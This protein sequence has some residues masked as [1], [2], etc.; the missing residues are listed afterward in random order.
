MPLR[1]CALGAWNERA[2]QSRSA[3]AKMPYRRP[4]SANEYRLP[5][6]QVVQNAPVYAHLTSIRIQLLRK[7]QPQL[8]TR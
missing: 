5:G 7:F 8:L 2:P 4:C 1:G 6:D 3:T